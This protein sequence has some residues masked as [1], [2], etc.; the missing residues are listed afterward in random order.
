MRLMSEIKWRK[1]VYAK[2]SSEAGASQAENGVK[3]QSFTVQGSKVHY[4]RFIGSA[5]G[6][7]FPSVMSSGP[8]GS[9]FRTKE[10]RFNS[11]P[12]NSIFAFIVARDPTSPK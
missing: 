6:K 7:N 2:I 4:S 9:G 12:Q 3:G 11:E 1:L 8:N 5:T 10:S